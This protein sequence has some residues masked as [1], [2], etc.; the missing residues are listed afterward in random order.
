MGSVKIIHMSKLDVAGAI[1]KINGEQKGGVM[2][3]AIFFDVE[4][5]FLEVCNLLFY[6]IVPSFLCRSKSK[7]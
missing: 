6:I 2:E 7:I 5:V 1:S 4:D 3:V